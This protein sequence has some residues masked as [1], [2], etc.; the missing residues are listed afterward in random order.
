[1]GLLRG[2]LKKVIVRR[3]GTKGNLTGGHGVIARGKE[4]GREEVG[5]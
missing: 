5:K 2:G 3:T 4:Q 1:M